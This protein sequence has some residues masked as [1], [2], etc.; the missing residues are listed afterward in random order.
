[1]L[2]GLQIFESALVNAALILAAA[3]IA[4]LLARHRSWLLW[5]RR[6][7]GLLLAAVGLTLALGA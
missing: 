3:G 5:Q 4:G 7:M 2:G 1:M 6:V